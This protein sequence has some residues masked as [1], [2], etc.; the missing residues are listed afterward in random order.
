MVDEANGTIQYVKA[1]APNIHTHKHIHT[2]SRHTVNKRPVSLKNVFYEAI[3][4]INFIIFL[5][6]GG[7]FFQG[8]T[9][10]T[11]L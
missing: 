3:E 5:P 10:I 11:E 6:K 8:K 4:T 9:F 1:V 2:S 7:R